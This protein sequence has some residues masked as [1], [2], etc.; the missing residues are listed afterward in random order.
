MH[1]DL[2]IQTAWCQ[3]GVVSHQLSVRGE[4]QLLALLDAQVPADG[5]L[6]EAAVEECVFVWVKHLISIS[7]KFEISE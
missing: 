3:Q 2:M 5:R 1:P 6:D 7:E 4:Q